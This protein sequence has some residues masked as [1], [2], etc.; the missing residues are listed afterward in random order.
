MRIGTCF[1]RPIRRRPSPASRPASPR[2]APATK[3]ATRRAKT[4][5][6]RPRR[7]FPRTSLRT[8]PRRRPTPRP[9]NKAKAEPMMLNLHTIE[10]GKTIL[11]SGDSVTDCGRARPY[12]DYVSGLGGGYPQNL[13]TLITA[14]CPEKRLRLVNAGIGGETS[15]DVRSRWESDLDAVRPDH[16]TLLIGVNDVWRHF[17]TYMTPSRAVS[18]EEYEENLRFI[19]SIAA[20][21][22]ESFTL[23]APFLFETNKRDAFFA[24]VL[25]YAKI[26]ERVA[27][28]T[29]CDFINPQ[30]DIDKALR[31]LN[32]TALSPDRVHPNAVAHMIVARSILKHWHYRF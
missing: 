13:H 4:C 17:D 12:G 23:I 15:R 20:K 30:K 10:N 14:A 16:A 9:K 8:F 6:A 24:A 25:R 1:P 28:D 27:A 7:R 11:L 18:E 31:S 29:G 26:C 32:N 2:K 3:A 5:P 21:R 22:L 19:A